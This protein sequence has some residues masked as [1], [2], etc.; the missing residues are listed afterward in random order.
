MMIAIV[1]ESK[2][3]QQEA[4]E[5]TKVLLFFTMYNLS[6]FFG[7]EGRTMNFVQVFKNKFQLF[8][9]VEVCF[10]WSCWP[11]YS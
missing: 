10:N 4:E 9:R 1:E 11:S 5:N 6:L 3:L 2:K 7:F 8:V